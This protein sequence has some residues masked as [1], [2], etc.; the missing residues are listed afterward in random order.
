MHIAIYTQMHIHKVKCD[1]MSEFANTYLPYSGFLNFHE[2][3]KFYII[4]ENFLHEI[5]IY[6]SLKL[7]VILS[8]EDTCRF[9]S[10]FK[11]FKRKDLAPKSLLVDH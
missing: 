9:M 2:F 11:Y 1:C 10:L 8:I 5:F 6:N 7:C 4:R 3:H